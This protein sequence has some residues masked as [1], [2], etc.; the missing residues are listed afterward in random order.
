MNTFYFKEFLILAENL[1][2]SKAAKS[3]GIN[4]SALSRHIKQLEDELGVPLFNRTTQKIEL[5]SYGVAF[6]PCA[7]SILQKLTEY[8]H[9]VETIQR[10]N[11][12]RISIG[13]CGF[14]SY[15]GI[16]ALFS[17]FKHKYPET[18]INVITDSHNDLVKALESGF[19]DVAFIHDTRLLHSEYCAVP[20]CKDFMSVCLPAEHPLASRESLGLTDL[21][22]ETFYIRDKKDSHMY[23]LQMNILRRA[24]LEPRISLNTGTWSDS[25]IN[26][27]NE[28]SLVLQGLAENLSHNPH[29]HVVKLTPPIHVDIYLIYPRDRNLSATAKDFIEFVLETHP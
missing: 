19:L 28:I 15:Y 23:R 4:Q 29:V 24:G 5:T 18:A 14:P 26:R 2:F 20:F 10:E 17:E 7:D 1:S 27:Q 9:T 21:A 3:I 13:V 11:S 6:I 22:E 8:N 25:I 12:S 16:T